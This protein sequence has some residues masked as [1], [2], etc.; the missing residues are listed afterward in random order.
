MST[1]RNVTWIG[2]RTAGSEPHEMI[3]SLAGEYLGY[4]WV[5]PDFL[6]IQHIK[7]NIEQ[8]YVSEN[9]KK[10]KVVLGIHDGKEYLKT[11]QDSY[12]P[13]TL[14]HLPTLHIERLEPVN[15]RRFEF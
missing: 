2:K 1:K 4:L 15:K 14:L 9:G 12:S 3:E 6:V 13:D 11:E 7:R 5:L 10:I 8:Y